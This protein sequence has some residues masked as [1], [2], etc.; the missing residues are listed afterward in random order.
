MANKVFKGFKQVTE[1][2]FEAENG[3]IYFVRKTANSAR[4]DGYILF[5]GRN[6]GTA[7]EAKAELEA[8][9]GTL[10]EGFDNVVEYVNSKVSGITN[11]FSSDEVSG[12]SNGVEV[13]VG[14]SNGNVT[15]VTV[16]APDFANTY[17]SKSDFETV[18]GTVSTINS[19][20]LTSTDKTGLETTIGTLSGRVDALETS[21]TVVIS[22]Y[23]GSDS[24]LTE[25][26][27][28]TYEVFQG[29]SSVGKIDIPKD[30]VV[31]S[32]S[33]V[34]VE[35][36]K[37]LRLTIANSDTPVDI[38]VADLAH[39][40]TEGNGI[41]ISSADTI[42]AKVVAANGLS[43]DS[44]GIALSLADGS[45]NGA[46]SSSDFQKLGTI[47]V[48]AQTN[49]IEEVKV[50]GSALTV[51]EKSVNIELPNYDDT[52]APISLTGTVDTNRTAF[53]NY[54]STTDS[55]IGTLS[56]RVDTLET[57]SADTRL[58]AL[59]AIS[60]KTD[61]ALQSVSAGDTSVS[62]GAKDSNNNQTVAVAISAA[63]GNTI[64]LKNDGLFAAIYYDGDDSE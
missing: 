47:A 20:Y 48:S 21:T 6:Y 12:T 49:V 28:K 24:G 46:M 30:L 23:T 18:S 14:Q 25:G 19:D 60:G 54:T 22:A 35:D 52:Y 11:N 2:T 31:S 41:E 51:T 56:G 64:E 3:Y 15:A 5:N 40:Y 44:S 8:K 43:V 13:H 39:V 62:V 50:N 10:P 26:Y 63:S 36:A 17:A 45:N 59:E 61:S 27:L 9:V 37:Y 1:G 58:D 33:I 53:D 4:T 7:A 34:E 16:S 42:S 32:G 29:G 38:A 55:S 57:V